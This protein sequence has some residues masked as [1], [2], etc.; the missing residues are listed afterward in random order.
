MNKVPL[1]VFPNGS[2]RVNATLPRTAA[3]T[4]QSSGGRWYL[5]VAIN[6]WVLTGWA[7]R[8]MS[9][10]GSRISPR[11]RSVLLV[12]NEVPRGV[13]ALVK[14]AACSVVL[15]ARPPGTFCLRCG[16]ATHLSSKVQI[17]IFERGKRSQFVEYRL[18]RDDSHKCRVCLFEFVVLCFDASFWFSHAE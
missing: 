16:A 18:S 8:I 10:R 5:R 6:K 9:P 7:A 1:R 17:K 12:T 15:P 11:P 13:S 3:V 14:T 2:H 4:L